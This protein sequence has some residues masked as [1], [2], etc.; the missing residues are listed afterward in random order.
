MPPP[1]SSDGWCGRSVSG[2]AGL[3]VSSSTALTSPLTCCAS[4][5]S[6]TSR[7]SRTR[8][9]YFCSW[10]WGWT[11]SS[12]RTICGTSRP[13]GGSLLARSRQTQRALHGSQGARSHPRPV[14][15]PCDEVNRRGQPRRSQYGRCT[16][17]QHRPYQQEQ[18]VIPRRYRPPGEKPRHRR[19]VAAPAPRGAPRGER[20]QSRG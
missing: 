6:E 17:Q 2:W 8:S 1:A 15:P 13:A 20:Q 12:S 10:R 18:R 11:G 4:W 7:Y 16:G 5:R 19:R 9:T 14:V 3:V